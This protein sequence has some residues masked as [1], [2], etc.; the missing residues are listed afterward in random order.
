MNEKYVNIERLNP[1]GLKEI[2]RQ[3]KRLKVELKNKVISTPAY[4]TKVKSSYD[5]K[6]LFGEN[7]LFH[8]LKGCFFDISN[9]E[10][11]IKE[12][13]LRIGQRDLSMEEIRTTYEKIKEE[14]FFLVDPSTEYFYFNAYKRTDFLKI[15]DLPYIIKQMLKYS[16]TKTHYRYWKDIMEGKSKDS[17]IQYIN[18]F[19]KYQSRYF[20][21]IILPPTPFIS[22]EN[23]NLVKYA[24]K[25]NTKTYEVSKN[26]DKIPSFY[27]PIHNRVL[28]EN[29][30]QI[31]AILDFLYDNL[32]MYK[33]VRF[34]FFKIKNYDIDE[35]SVFRRNLKFFLSELSHISDISQKATIILDARVLGLVAI[36]SGIDG[37]CEP[38]DGLIRDYGRKKRGRGRIYNP[39]P[40]EFMSYNDF[41][42][43][44]NSN[45]RNFPR[46]GVYSEQFNGTDLDTIEDWNKFRRLYL[47]E[48][49][50]HELEEIHSMIT[51]GITR[52]FADKISKS[53]R[54]NYLDVLA[55]GF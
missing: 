3:A 47:L 19:V 25:I 50:D 24:I 55:N 18:W 44:Y 2:N 7:F 40:M 21:D 22:G 30:D 8:N 10:R 34:I 15:L 9:I 23:P 39:I 49:R 42:K 45:G 37:F 14:F 1:D 20:A 43:F 6:C 46:I 36:H 53:G 33:D 5:A 32:E 48:C 13:E 16:N 26:F 17:Q 12:W 4:F 35:S 54:K 28:R 38:L 27:F 11:V 29:E 31:Q 41:R 51:E 52:G